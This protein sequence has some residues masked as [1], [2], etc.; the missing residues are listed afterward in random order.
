MCG[1]AGIIG[2]NGSVGVRERLGA[3]ASGMRHRGPDDGAFLVWQPGGR[4]EVSAEV[5]SGPGSVVMAHR[6]LSILD[7][8]PRGRQPMLT[9]DG[10]HAVCFNG[11]IYN[12]R[13]L[14]AGLEAGGVVFRTETDT[15]VLL[16]L[17]RLRGA[18]ALPMLRGMF[19]FAFLD[20]EAGEVLLGRDPFGIKPLYLAESGGAV[21]FASELQTLR[22]LGVDG[23][24]LDPQVVY[25]FLRFGVS[26][27]GRTT[28]HRG[29]V[30]L[31]PGH[32]VKVEV[33]AVSIGEP[34]RYW[35]PAL[36][37]PQRISFAE[38]A[39]GIRERFLE[40]V[41]LHLRSDV[42]VG[43]ALSGGIDS[44]A[45]VACM[46]KLE[47]DAEIHAFSYVPAGFPLSE[48][49]WARMAADRARVQL[50]TVDFTAAEL[51]A[52]LD[53]LI[54]VQGEPFGSTSIYAQ[55]RIF[56]KV[57]EVGIP[58]VLDGQGGDETLAGYSI[59]F[60]ARL[61]GM[62]RRG[63]WGAVARLWG[64]RRN[65]GG[66]HMS[67][68]FQAAGHVLP[69]WVADAG[70][71][72]VGK[73]LLPSWMRREYFAGVRTGRLEAGLDG[74]G[75]RGVLADT[76]SRTII[77][78]LLHFEDRNSMA[79][80]VESRVPFL[81][82]D[83][84]E[85]ALSLPEEYLVGGDGT[86]KRV[87]REAM[88]GLVPDAILDRRDKIGFHTPGNLMLAEARPWVEEILGSVPAAA[89]AV[90]DPA[91][92]RRLWERTLAGRTG[93]DHSFWRTLCFLRWLQLSPG[94][95]I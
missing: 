42:P 71:H 56:R 50:H 10:K 66:G 29:V 87:F 77:P 60:A 8:S 34:V 20:V 11:E 92:L 22:S 86:M 68:W 45:I 95:R 41:R 44:S 76:L 2:G 64:S 38:A 12:Y 27:D 25:Q 91:G 57:R 30:Q 94:I 49:R 48:E 37:E 52:D 26:D 79:W 80:S 40:S 61:A 62:M 81:H 85:F 28:F 4:P 18:E 72:L 93:N 75:M 19:A 33:G 69:R 63:E 84:A 17:L 21:V 83:F 65:A 90:I 9:V 1:I 47:P 78:Q 15:E 73:E 53:E 13:E 5:P 55:Y 31:P 54:R 14:R 39:E 89:E 23:G 59:Y 7:L 24:P 74:H 32:W 43:A 3:A 88:R 16:E 82:V 70:R 35:S 36:A 51:A 6:R 46:R 67:A 58:V